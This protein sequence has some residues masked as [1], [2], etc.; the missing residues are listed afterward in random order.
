MAEKIGLPNQ[1]SGIA[2]ELE[3]EARPRL[4]W[5]FLT[6]SFLSA[7]LVTPTACL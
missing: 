3:Q 4:T 1:W 5:T 2:K 7:Y 6:H